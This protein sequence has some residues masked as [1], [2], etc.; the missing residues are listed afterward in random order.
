MNTEI[1]N[2][3]NLALAN[4]LVTEKERAI[5]LNKAIELGE[6]SNEIEMILDGRLNQ[7]KANSWHSK[8][9]AGSIKACPCCGSILKPFDTVC[10]DCQHVLSEVT[11]GMSL[12]SLQKSLLITREEFQRQEL[13]R[14]FT[15]Q[16]DRESIIDT[17]HFLFG[18]VVPE[19][20]TEFELKTN[21]TLKQKSLE[22]ITRALLYY[23]LD[24]DFTTKIRAFHE[25]LDDKFKTTSHF[26]K[27]GERKR[28]NWLLS[29]GLSFLII[30]SLAYLLKRLFPSLSGSGMSDK[31]LLFWSL[32]SIILIVV[33]VYFRMEYKRHAR[34]F[35]FL[36]KIK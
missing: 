6:D 25:N 34:T 13:I 27:I 8:A 12:Q 10:V 19:S 2:L 5:I 7:I 30:M 22:I 35:D 33:S 32:T 1:D 16:K 17:L 28:R 29:S 36:E 21:D 9:Y 18:Q 11:A 3:I 15:P 23:D 20:P 31:G 4:G 14:R 24:K 26:L